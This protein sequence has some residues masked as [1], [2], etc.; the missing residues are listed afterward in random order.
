M[1]NNNF[2][3]KLIYLITN[4]NFIYFYYV[5]RY[6]FKKILIYFVVTQ[7]TNAYQ[8]YTDYNDEIRGLKELINNQIFCKIL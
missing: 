6:L 7:R 2:N 3:F 4:Y 8:N 1:I 5:L